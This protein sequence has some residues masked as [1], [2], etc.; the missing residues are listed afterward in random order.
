MI[1]LIRSIFLLAFSFLSATEF[2]QAINGAML[3]E[4]LTKEYPND[5]EYFYELGR[6]YDQLQKWDQAIASFQHALKMQPNNPDIR[7]AL[8]YAYLF[9]Y[10]LQKED[11]YKSEHLFKQVLRS[12]PNYPEAAEGLK[13]A[14]AL[15]TSPEKPSLHEDAEVYYKL[16]RTF[17]ETK[18]WKKAIEAFEQ[19]LKLQ[20]DH[21]DA[22]LALAYSYLFWYQTKEILSDSEKLFH[23][24][25]E[26]VPDYQDAEDGLERIYTL[27][28][29]E[30][31]KALAPTVE[32]IALQIAKELAQTE[33]HCG[34]IEIYLKLT[35]AFPKNAEYFYLLGIEYI[36]AD[37]HCSAISAL[38]QAIAL[39]P[40]YADALVALGG[41]Y[42]FFYDFPM[43][44]EYYLEALMAAPQDLDALLGLA[45]VDALLDFPE[46]AEE[47]YLTALDIDPENTDALNSYAAF[48]F[49][50]RRFFES[51]EIYNYLAFFNPDDYRITLFNLTS[52]TTPSMFTNSGV[53]EEKEKN[54]FTHKWE[55]ALQY[56]NSEL[57]VV[58]PINEKMR[59]TLR[60]R[61][62]DVRQLNLLAHTTLFALQSDTFGLREEWILDPF[63]T[64][65]LDTRL[66][67]ISNN[68][69]NVQLKTKRTTL[70]E[71]SLAF[72]LD[73][74]P[75][76]VAFAALSD[77][78]IYKDFKRNKVL[79]V[80]REA[81]FISFLHDFGDYRFLGADATWFWYFDPVR[82]QERDLNGWVLAGVPYFEDTLSAGY[83]CQ[84]RAFRKDVNA[85]YSFEYQLTHW[86]RLRYFKNW[87]IGGR[88]ELDYWHGW[89]TTRGMNPQQQLTISAVP[90]P[91]TTVEYQV[92]QLFLTVGYT[93]SPCLDLAFQGFYYH[94]S[95]DYTVWLGKLGCEWRF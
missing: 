68:K 86:L 66:E 60:A 57:G 8:A 58:F 78:I 62:G 47:F 39:K 83:H 95:F 27:E 25:L 9:S 38:N 14:E 80:P 88:I 31:K 75:D 11:L 69:R 49:N 42:F 41:Q 43:S 26:E 92:D 50:R 63:W 71:P 82:N 45:R 79:V 21:P 35:E 76:Q 32:Q 40:D 73:K 5:P 33:N 61:A 22:E 28:R 48:L 4:A 37:Y 51:E 3:Y 7:L 55:A 46:E 2:D 70:L 44:R 18:E 23:Q 10:Q 29:E 87:C 81:A 19:A 53:A 54:I 36:R 56:L 24:V 89:R 16:G 30:K 64:M 59:T 1:K 77:S 20:P 72:R 94:D 15:H 52:Y 13:R 17:Y 90:T 34:A 74:F 91:I 93:F 65:I 85:Y 6:Y 67:F 12:N 84:Y